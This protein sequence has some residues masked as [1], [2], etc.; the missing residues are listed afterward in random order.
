MK[1]REP[2]CERQIRV[3]VPPAV[4]SGKVALTGVHR[5]FYVNTNICFFGPKISPGLGQADATRGGVSAGDPTAGEVLVDGIP[6]T[7]VNLHSWRQHVCPRPH[8]LFGC[9]RVRAGRRVLVRGAGPRQCGGVRR[10]LCAPVSVC[11]SLSDCWGVR[12]RIVFA[13]LARAL[14]VRPWICERLGACTRACVRVCVSVCV[15]ASVSPSGARECVRSG[16]VVLAT[17]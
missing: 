14:S 7:D 5:P 8:C 17:K 4:P 10:R 9:V 16:V 3:C 12:S 1:I 6:L 15:C 11:A 2:K 13:L